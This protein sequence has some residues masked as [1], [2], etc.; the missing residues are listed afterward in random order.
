MTTA[1]EKIKELSLTNS[2]TDAYLLLQE[3]KEL[4]RSLSLELD[5]ARDRRKAQEAEFR[6]F[7]TEL[8]KTLDKIRAQFRV[9]AELLNL[10]N[11]HDRSNNQ[12]AGDKRRE[13][14]T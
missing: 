5:L 10:I 11:A 1:T 12:D 3:I 6:Q 7:M 2:L 9:E 4:K 8:W 14:G 13:K